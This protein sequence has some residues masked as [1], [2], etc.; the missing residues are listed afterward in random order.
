MADHLS[1]L[2]HRLSRLQQSTNDERDG[3]RRMDVLD[4][5]EKLRNSVLRQ[6]NELKQLLGMHG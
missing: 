4:E 3:Q 2:L 1:A 5:L 6:I